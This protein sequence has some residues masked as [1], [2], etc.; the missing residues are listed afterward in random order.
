[1]TW[2]DRQSFLGAGSDKR[3]GALTIGIVG[4]GGGGSHIAQQLAHVGIGHFV[5]VD[6]DEIDETNLNRLVGGTRIDVDAKARKVDIAERL[7]RMVNP[8]AHILTVAQKWQQ[9]VDALS[10]CDLIFGCLDNVRGKDELEGFCRRLLIP[11]I[12]QGMDVHA[13]DEHYL[14]AGQ[15]VLSVP[16]GPCLRCLGIVTEEALEEEARNYGAAGGKPQVIWPNGVLASTA[17]GLFLQ[18]VTPWHR[19]V[20]TG[21]A[22]EYDGNAHSVQASDRFRRLKGRPCLHRPTDELGDPGFDV[23]RLMEKPSSQPS[24][25]APRISLILRLWRLVCR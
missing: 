14:I 4:L 19:S 20:V 12:D 8:T 15:V 13:I 18:L 7:I 17:V 6:D 21:A 10:A 23:R 3:L 11:Y 5:L 9:A 2:L 16:G 25:D 24:A 22:L 1:M